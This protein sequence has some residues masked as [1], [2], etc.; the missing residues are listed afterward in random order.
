[1]SETFPG[2]AVE[3]MT[4]GRVVSAVSLTR[5]KGA[6]VAC[7]TANKRAGTARARWAYMRHRAEKGGSKDRVTNAELSAELINEKLNGNRNDIDVDRRSIQ[8]LHV[9]QV[10]GRSYGHQVVDTLSGDVEI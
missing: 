9:L 6:R 3:A 2:Q 5:G 8:L 10:G 4:S 7:R 1:M